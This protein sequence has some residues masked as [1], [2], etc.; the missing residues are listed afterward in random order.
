MSDSYEPV[1]DVRFW[2]ERY[3]E[4]GGDLHRAIFTGSAD[5]L[6][7]I[8][9]GQIPQ[10]LEH[11]RPGESILDAGCGYGRF[12][13]MF[14]DWKGQYLGID[15][16]PEFILEARKRHPRRDFMVVDLLNDPIPWPGPRPDEV[17]PTWDVGLLIGVEGMIRR[18]LGEPTWRKIERNLMTVCKRLVRIGG[19]TFD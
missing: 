4:C 1:C 11:L 19:T 16:V 3:R 17:V 8:E 7:E 18:N 6:A 10:L 14:P 12:L 9:R 13:D 15:F 2:Q 5:Q